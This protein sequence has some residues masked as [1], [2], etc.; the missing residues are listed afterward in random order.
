MPPAQRLVAQ[1]AAAAGDP[2]RS[3]HAL[4]HRTFT[5][6]MSFHYLR[7]MTHF[8]PP[9]CWV[10][11]WIRSG[12]VGAGLW[13]RR[14]GSVQRP[15]PT[16]TTSSASAENGGAKKDEENIFLFVVFCF[17]LYI[18][19]LLQV[20]DTTEYIYNSS[21][22]DRFSSRPSCLSEIVA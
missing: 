4:L 5:C 16:P 2:L 1:I 15:S 13:R 22:R 10:Y 19:D 9:P 17:F 8:V 6:R 21:L 7:S 18:G 11:R 3:L 14:S 20:Y 12:R